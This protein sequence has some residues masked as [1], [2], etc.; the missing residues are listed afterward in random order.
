MLAVSV[1][2]TSTVEFFISATYIGGSPLAEHDNLKPGNARITGAGSGSIT[3]VEANESKKILIK[4]RH[5]KKTLVTFD[6]NYVHVS[7]LFFA[8]YKFQ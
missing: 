6:V 5:F 7:F 1:V 4:V 8:T 3:L 2:F